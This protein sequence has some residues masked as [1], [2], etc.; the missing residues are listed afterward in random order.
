MRP[1]WF[2]A[3]PLDRSE[4]LLPFLD[5]APDGLRPFHHEDMHLTIAFLGAL[6]A[7]A[8]HHV[9]QLLRTCKWPRVEATLGKLLPLPNAK[10][11]SALSFELREGRNEMV[12]VMS[13]YRD[14]LH[15]TA[16]I[17]LDRR[18]PLPHVTIGRPRRRASVA[19][20]LDLL[21]WGATL[22]VSNLRFCFDRVVLYTW[23]DDRS[24]RQFKKVCLV[25]AGSE[26]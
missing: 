15:R 5:H 1:N 8:Q 25:D 7:T 17:P 22:D 21:A 4:R 19:A 11:F 14:D 16:G 18:P 13:A 23:A 20:R 10:R 26:L 9:T 24:E 3:Y 2:V 6:E 12:A